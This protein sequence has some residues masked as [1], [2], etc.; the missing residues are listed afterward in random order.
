MAYLS[1][2]R[3]PLLLILLLSFYSALYAQGDNSS[4]FTNLADTENFLKNLYNSRLSHELPLNN[5]KFHYAYSRAIEGSPYF[6][7]DDW[8][9]GSVV[10]DAILYENVMMKYDLVKD[11]LVIRTREAGG[12]YISLFSPRVE[13]FSFSGYTFIYLGQDAANPGMPAGFYL[14]LVKGK[15]TAVSKATKIITEEIVS[16]SVKREFE[17]KN[18]YYI[19]KNNQ[20]SPV[21]KK[22]G[23]FG[24][25]REHRKEIQ[26]LLSKQR[27]KFKK[28]PQATII[29]AVNVYNQ[30][31]N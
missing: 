21:Y 14:Q 17:E 22:S 29:T 9:S 4:A 8:Q 24:I 3:K 7:Y 5:G 2:M 12:L 1:K 19:L 18:S 15:V 20:Y 23:L 26:D 27:L 30:N 13:S 6:K 10:Y 31:E 16:M 25:L 28:D 11:V